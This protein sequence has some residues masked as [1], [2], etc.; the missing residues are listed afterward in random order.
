MLLAYSLWGVWYLGCVVCLFLLVC[1]S[2]GVWDNTILVCLVVCQLLCAELCIIGC[3]LYLTGETLDVNFQV[4]SHTVY[5][6]VYL[7]GYC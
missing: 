5:V 6:V 7:C 2:L 3:V 1:G 4:C